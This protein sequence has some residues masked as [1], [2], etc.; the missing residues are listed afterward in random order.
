M[1]PQ[2]TWKNLGDLDFSDSND[3][4]VKGSEMMANGAKT[5]VDQFKEIAAKNAVIE[6]EQRDTKF[7]GAIQGMSLAQD[8]NQLRQSYIE[9][10]KVD[11]IGADN[12][13]K[14]TDTYKGYQQGILNLQGKRL[15]NTGQ[16]LVN[17][18]RK[19]AIDYTAGTQPLKIQS[20]NAVN[21]GV[22]NTIQGKVASTNSTNAL[23]LKQNAYKG[24]QIDSNTKA[25]LPFLEAQQKAAKAN[26]G[27]VGA[28]YDVR[29]IQAKI[30]AGVPI[31][32]AE[33]RVLNNDT[34]QSNNLVQQTKNE[35]Y[36]AAGLPTL[37]AQG[38]AS[39]IRAGVSNDQIT[40]A[41]NTASARA[42]LPQRQVDQAI[43]DISTKRSNNAYK[44]I[45][46][47]ANA[48]NDV[49]ENEAKASVSNSKATVSN[50]R[51]KRVVIDSNLNNNIPELTAKSEAQ[52]Q[53]TKATTKAFEEKFTKA[54]DRAGVIDSE[55][56][57]NL[58]AN[59]LNTTKNKQ[60]KEILDK[61]KAATVGTA[62]N[63]ARANLVKSA[64]ASENSFNNAVD[65]QKANTAKLRSETA[66]YNALDDNYYSDQKKA[67]LLKVRDAEDLR[68]ARIQAE[69]DKST[70]SQ[71]KVEEIKKTIK[72]R[73]A[74]SN[75]V[76]E[77][78]VASQNDKALSPTKMYERA[79]K[80]LRNKG[81][82]LTP[83]ESLQMFNHFTKISK[84]ED[85]R[86]TTLKGSVSKFAAND[87]TI[88]DYYDNLT[89][90][91]TELLDTVM[92]SLQA[93]GAII[94]G[95]IVRRVEPKRQKEYMKGLIEHMSKNT[96]ELSPITFDTTHA[97]EGYA[98]YNRN[99][100]NKTVNE[101]RN[102]LKINKG[103]N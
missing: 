60:G 90:R 18:S 12:V 96:D 63:E 83:E 52:A 99:W 70:A 58:S 55:I 14:L 13:L 21:K 35:A 6:K 61:T 38:K 36:V 82:S 91:D 32:D 2:I 26:A 71:V 86:V 50:S 3:L 78:M 84:F 33:T 95:G 51:Y 46:N 66:K 45:V 30:D 65:E 4:R 37:E 11:G 16:G 64:V 72:R 102:P 39:K 76:S 42:G 19:Q 94:D 77:T 29:V 62:V 101:T 31:S 41:S 7:A 8:E 9:A 73:R 10:M 43:D 59:K 24:S 28:D 92:A 47:Q 81:E 22:L 79:L 93:S 20:D 25:Q 23:T 88:K 48:S 15:D 34:S 75:A 67:E 74:I 27:A 1:M 53:K 69:K 100:F 44:R 57:A 80:S 49:P 98:K 40:V 68:K 56:N 5:I 54:K 89:N 97:L 17:T 103:R 85:R 87:D